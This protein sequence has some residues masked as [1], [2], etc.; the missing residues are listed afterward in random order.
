MDD[1]T[2]LFLNGVALGFLLVSNVFVWRHSRASAVST[3]LTVISTEMARLRG[4]FDVIREGQ[5]E[6]NRD[7]IKLLHAKAEFADALT[8]SILKKFGL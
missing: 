5:H 6:V 8:R 4:Q 7:E 2:R 3:M 1:T